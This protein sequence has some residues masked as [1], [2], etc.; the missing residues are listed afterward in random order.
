GKEVRRIA[1]GPLHPLALA[2][3]PNGKTLALSS[4]NGA[5]RLFD[6]ARGRELPRGAGPYGP[7]LVTALTPDGR[8]LATLGGRAVLLWD[9]ATGRERQRLEGHAA[10]VMSL[11]LAAD[12]RTLFSGGLDRTLRAW[13]LASGKELRRLSLEHLPFWP[14]LMAVS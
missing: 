5:I 13:D 2:F 4:S 14:P 7:L 9:T 12:G 3:S 6:L 10:D 1:C 11:H 8:T